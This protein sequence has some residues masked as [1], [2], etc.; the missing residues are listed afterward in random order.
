[1]NVCDAMTRQPA[2]CGPES[3]AYR[4]IFI[5]SSPSKT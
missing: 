3:K 4:A 5:H 2:S 1:M